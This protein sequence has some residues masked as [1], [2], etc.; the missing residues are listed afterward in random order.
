M[1]RRRLIWFCGAGIVLMLTSGSG[2]IIEV[3][4]AAPD[5]KAAVRAKLPYEVLYDGLMWLLFG[6]TLVSLLLKLPTRRGIVGQIQRLTA[7]AC[8]LALV[9]EG[10]TA[11]MAPGVVLG[12]VAP[13]DAAFWAAFTALCAVALVF[14]LAM[15][16]IPMR[17]R[18]SGVI[19][20]IIAIG[21]VGALPLTI[22]A[23]VP[24][25]VL[26]MG[27]LVVILAI[28]MAWSQW[29]FIAFDDRFKA[30]EMQAQLREL[31]G[32]MAYARRVHEA[33]FPPAFQRGSIRVRYRYE[34]MR[35]VGGDFLF[36]H[37]ESFAGL[38]LVPISVVLID[39]SGHGIPA[40]LTVNRL[41]GE[42]QRFYG[43]HPTASPGE[44]IT[45]L[46]TFAFHAMAPQGMFATALCL[47][48]DPMS[49]ELR[50]ANAGH[51]PGVLRKAE[52]NI[53]D[54]AATTTML[55]VL[56]AK[57]F[58]AGEVMIKTTL[59]ATVLAYTDGAFEA[60]N[61]KSEF[62]TI[63]R[64]REFGAAAAGDRA[65][66]LVEAVV[67]FRSG[68]AQDDLLAVE[69]AWG[70]GETI[71]RSRPINPATRLTRMITGTGQK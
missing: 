50:Y 6:G 14:W 71:M 55:G 64:V 26:A 23:T 61:D 1:L 48:V 22:R 31:T 37:P 54:L 15:A 7:G 41:H 2:H 13:S 5:V 70:E 44:L 11:H 9:F 3:M 28:G 35:E 20:A 25:C 29:R 58:D 19:A 49:R 12:R 21:A 36:V 32:E 8:V 18:E 43:L 30:V 53:I 67:K 56:E 42:L 40:A 16:L 45:A 51:P 65:K 52:G 63:E 38:G 68:K 69:V 57:E 62:F 47:Q 4:E 10:I 66:A 33:L 60:K 17:W 39:V 46:N 34:P 24:Q 59:G 27:V